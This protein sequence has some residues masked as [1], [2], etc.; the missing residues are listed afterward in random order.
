[1]PERKPTP[2]G[3]LFYKINEVGNI[4]GIKPHVLRYWESEFTEL[5]PK[6]DTNDQRL[7]KQ[8]EIEL[9]LKIKQLLYQDMYTIAGARKLLKRTGKKKIAKN[10]DIESSLKAIKEELHRIHQMVGEM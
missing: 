2:K 3:K 8:A 7:Y 4:T 6:K 10:I 5:K 1:M 9:I